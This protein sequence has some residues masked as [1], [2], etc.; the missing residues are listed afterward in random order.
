MGRNPSITL[1]SILL[2]LIGLLGAA[3]IVLFHTRAQRL[4][5]HR[6]ARAELFT[7]FLRGPTYAALFLGVPNLSFGGNWFHGLCGL[8]AFDLA[9]SIADFWLEPESRGQGH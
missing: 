5:A 4:H 7:H 2:F 6:P 3:D 9:I 1:P 8:L